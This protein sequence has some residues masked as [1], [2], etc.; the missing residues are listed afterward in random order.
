M[1]P[2]FLNFSSIVVYGI[3]YSQ[4][5]NIGDHLICSISARKNVMV[6]CYRILKELW[7]P[8]FFTFSTFGHVLLKALNQFKEILNE[9]HYNRKK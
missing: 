7:N 4:F 5:F 2:L 3:F 9:L 8:V 6:I 1:I